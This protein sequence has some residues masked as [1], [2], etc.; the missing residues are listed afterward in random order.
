M[1]LCLTKAGFRVSMAGDGVMALRLAEQEP[2]HLVISDYFMTPWLGSEFIKEL[3]QIEG[4]ATTPVIL[5][6]A[7]AVELNPLFFRDELSTVVLPNPCQPGV[8]LEAVSKFLGVSQV[9]S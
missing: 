8:L 5:V 4:Y 1:A 9:S 6:T 3:R 2:F 7:Y